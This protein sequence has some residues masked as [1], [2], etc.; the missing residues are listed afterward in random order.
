MA[1]ESPAPTTGF[2]ALL[3]LTTERGASDLHLKSGRPP[4]LRINGR[5]QATDLPALEPDTI[6]A[7]VDAI[8]DERTRQILRETGSV[9]FSRSLESGDRFR[10]NVYRQRGAISVAARRVSRTIPTFDELHLPGEALR[11]ISQ[12]QQGL[13]IFSGMTGSGKSTSIASCIEHI[14]QHRAC[15]IITLEDPIEYLFEDKEAFINQR[16]V[17]IDVPSFEA[18]LPA[19]LREDPDVV[20]IGEMRTRESLDG[21]LRAAVTSRLVFTTVH[22]SGAGRVIT[23]L[24]QLAGPQDH[25]RVREALANNLVAVVCQKLVPTVDPNVPRVPATEI[26]FATP[27]VRKAILEGEESRLAGLIEGG[28]DAGMH[29]MVQDLARLVREEW[30]APKDAYAAA[31][32]PEALKMAIRGIDFKRGTLR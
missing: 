18:A 4:M 31:P 28:Q 8:L 23:R 6:L 9:D 22:A 21:A 12:A 3:A 13:A 19:L 24:L 29:D 27:G 14:N 7:H 32:N 17:G 16:E 1:T 5:I 20:L 11:R 25:Q 10:L 30:V 26:M 2:D 15:H